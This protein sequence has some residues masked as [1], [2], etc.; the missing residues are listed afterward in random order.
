MWSCYFFGGVAT[1][2]LDDLSSTLLNVYDYEQN[3]YMNNDNFILF[4]FVG[5]ALLELGVIVEIDEK[6]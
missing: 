2:D 6:E 1:Y 4:S 5:M 3:N